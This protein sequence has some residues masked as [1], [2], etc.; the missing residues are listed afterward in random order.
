MKL[1]PLSLRLFVSVIE[2]GTIAAAAARE[3]IVASAVSKRLSELEI[4]LDTQLLQRSNK[5]IQPT[6]A[7]LALL[8]LARGVLH[9]LDDVYVQMR[10]YSSGTR[11]YVR[12]FANISA[13]TQ[14]LPAELSRF[15]EAYPLIQVHLEEKISSVI[16][17]SV[18]ESVADIGIF[19][20]GTH[21]QNLEIFPYGADELVLITPR[22]HPLA[23]KKSVRFS[24]TLEY[25][26]VGLHAGGSMHVQLA[27]VASQL[28][29]SLKLR[30]QVTSFDAQCLMVEAGMGIGILPRN[31]AKNFLKAL[32]INV[33]TLNES[34]AMRKLVICVRS[35][36]ALSLAAKFLV[37][38]L[39][40]PPS[41]AQLT[42]IATQKN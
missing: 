35:Y 41:P 27:T 32:N 28:G 42:Q 14:F 11:G 13:I 12:M 33:V 29:K 34:W 6:E 30:M 36:D 20:L 21:A 7:G 15:V 2:E 24:E 38:H 31:S 16:T 8:S 25:D 4:A 40:K 39:R 1:D 9:D 26:F 18:A 37:D 10:E 19:T 3:H 22:N 17:K 23:K 5:G